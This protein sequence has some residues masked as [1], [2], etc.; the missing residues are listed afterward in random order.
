MDKSIHQLGV[1]P[2]SKI[3][4]LTMVA[5]IG[6]PAH[7]LE[8]QA[9][10]LAKQRAGLMVKHTLSNLDSAAK[11]TTSKADVSTTAKLINQIVNQAEARG[12]SHQYIAQLAITN[13]PKLPSVVSQ[14]L[15]AAIS[16]SGLF[17][18]SHLS[19]LAGG[20]RPL[21]SIRQEPQN[22]LHQTAH[23]L[24]PQQ[25]HI[26][27]HQRLSWHGEVWPHQLMDWD[28]YLKDQQ[29]HA[30]HS[31]QHTDEDAPIASDLTIHLPHLGKV[32]AKIS[33]QNGRMRV[34]LLAEQKE[35]LQLFK[36]KSHALVNAIE[37]NGQKL[38]GFT[39]DAF[40]RQAP[41]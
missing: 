34:G 17:Y 40:N 9:S 13:N 37:R 19:D 7:N 26:L 41:E 38:E 21:A 20:Q 30:E 27:E 29:T 39:L 10:Q 16:Q 31:S 4:P 8:E 5:G 11:N 12:V 23:A 28:V 24:L 3:N 14:Q 15:K 2:L 1:K 36:D 32:T 25:L 22:Q 35:A 33:I 6:S 18:E